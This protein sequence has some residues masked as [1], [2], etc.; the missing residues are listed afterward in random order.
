MA[1]QE[2]TGVALETLEQQALGDTV[3]GVVVETLEFTLQIPGEN[4][5][6]VVIETL[7]WHPPTGSLMPLLLNL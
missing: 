5:T 7:E 4:I 6:S 3:R 1:G 2:V